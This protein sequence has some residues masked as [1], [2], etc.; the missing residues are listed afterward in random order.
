MPI[1][2]TFTGHRPEFA[3]GTLSVAEHASVV[4]TTVGGNVSGVVGTSSD[5]DPSWVFP[6][7]GRTVVGW[8]GSSVVMVKLHNFGPAE[9]GVNLTVRSTPESGLIGTGNVGGLTEVT[10]RHEETAFVRL[11]LHPPP[12]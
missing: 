7:S 3:N 1:A 4:W 5:V 6:L 8:I 9:V 10:S 12:S 11:G 2:V